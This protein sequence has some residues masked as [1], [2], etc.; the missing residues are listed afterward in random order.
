MLTGEK[1]RLRAVEPSDALMMYEVEND[2]DVWFYSSRV[3]PLSMHALSRYAC[4]TDSDPFRER[5]LRLVVELTDET[6]C[7]LLDLYE[8]NPIDRTAMAGIVILSQFRN[9]GLASEAIALLQ[10]YAAKILHLRALAARIPVTNT[11]SIRLF[12]SAGYRQVGLIPDWLISPDG[13]VDMAILW[14]DIQK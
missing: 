13:A 14:R 3:A 12:H 11:A 4:N 7:G 1:I 6:P 10:T 5:Q 2:P 8:I 9:K